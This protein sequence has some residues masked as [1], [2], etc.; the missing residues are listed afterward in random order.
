MD[1]GDLSHDVLLN[2]DFYFVQIIRFPLFLAFF[3]TFLEPE[4]GLLYLRV[5]V[6]IRS[7]NSTQHRCDVLVLAFVDTM[8]L[9]SVLRHA[10]ERLPLIV[11]HLLNC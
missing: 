7:T 4:L 1:H 10:D 3:V 11:H 2:F 9:V 6:K 5:L 8:S